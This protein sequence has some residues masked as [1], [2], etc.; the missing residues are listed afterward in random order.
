MPENLSAYEKIDIE[1]AYISEMPTIRIRRSNKRY[2][3]T[4]KSGFNID[5]SLST[6]VV[7]NE[8]ECEISEEEFN[9]LMNKSE[10][11]TLKKTRYLIPLQ[12]GKTAELDIFKERLEGLVFAEVE[13][14][15]VKEAENFVKPDWLGKDVSG[16]GRYR[17]SE[18]IKLGKYNAS[19]F[20]G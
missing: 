17:N 3:L 18:I 19:F 12:D 2:F 4:V 5:R 10:G 11:D 20:E 16:D 1:Q 13:F 14:D 9:N 15:T 6:A 7:N 8:F